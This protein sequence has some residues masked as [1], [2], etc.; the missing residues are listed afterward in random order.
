MMLPPSIAPRP[1][2]GHFLSSRRSRSALVA[3]TSINREGSS[4]PRNQCPSCDSRLLARPG[5]SLAVYAMP[6]HSIWV[7]EPSY[8]YCHW[9]CH[10]Q[11]RQTTR[12]RTHNSRTVLPR[13]PSFHHALFCSIR[14]ASCGVLLGHLDGISGITK[15]GGLHG[16]PGPCAMV[17]NCL[18]SPNANVIGV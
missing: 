13:K 12:N 18:P 15:C 9:Y 3:E 8:L 4:M 17:I 1:L 11:T 14:C 7:R 2:T 5:R 6:I 16:N 10:Q